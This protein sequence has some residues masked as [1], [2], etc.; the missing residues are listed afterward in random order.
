M[1]SGKI[2]AIIAGIVTLL[3]TYVFALGGGAGLVSSGIG[4][5]YGTINNLADLFLDS[6][7]YSAGINPIL[8]W[9]FII[10]FVIW[11]ASGVLQFIGIK[12]RVAIFIFS[13]FPLTLGIVFMLAL[14]APGVFG[15]T[16]G[17]LYI[18]F[19]FSSI[20]EQYGG[21]FPILINLGDAA[22]GVYLLIA[23][24]ALGLISAFL[25]RD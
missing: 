11:L 24:G 16:S 4:L 25:P 17:P 22:L 2:L 9:I 7:T 8:Y 5:I 10:L 21:F 3:G 18:L 19:V 20:G 23:G 15:G 6:A 1:E 13:L 14:Y 12:S